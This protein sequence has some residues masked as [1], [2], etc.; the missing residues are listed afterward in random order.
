MAIKPSQKLAK[1]FAKFNATAKARQ[2]K[3]MQDSRLVLFALLET[4]AKEI[5]TNKFP[6]FADCSD[7]KAATKR[8]QTCANTAKAEWLLVV[9]APEFC[10]V[11]AGTQNVRWENSIREAI[12]SYYTLEL[13]SREF[14]V[15]PNKAN[16][17]KPFIVRTN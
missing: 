9:N 12:K 15:V 1:A 5:P 8:Y 13:N 2:V 4:L 6:E 11:R 7:T 16:P 17:E 10:A 3:P 14:A